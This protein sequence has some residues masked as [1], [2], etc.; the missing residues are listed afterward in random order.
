M[1]TIFI[2]IAGGLNHLSYLLSISVTMAVIKDFSAIYME[3]LGL[4][5]AYM[6]L[7]LRNKY[8]IVLICSFQFDNGKYFT[9]INKKCL[10]II[11][12]K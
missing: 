11:P 5:Q 9:A 12:L 8:D 7:K 10:D 6:L 4:N 2:C 3:A 1:G